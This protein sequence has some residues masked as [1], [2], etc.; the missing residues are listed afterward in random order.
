MYVIFVANSPTNLETLLS[1][2]RDSSSL[3]CVHVEWWRR[4]KWEIKQLMG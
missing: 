2:P 1:M 3:W 4:Y